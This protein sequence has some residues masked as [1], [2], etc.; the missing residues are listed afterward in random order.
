VGA[1]GA[2][3]LVWGI[4]SLHVSGRSEP[5]MFLLPVDFKVVQYAVAVMF[6]MIGTYLLVLAVLGRI[7]KEGLDTSRPGL[8]ACRWG[9]MSALITMLLFGIPGTI[10][11]LEGA[12]V[13]G[14]TVSGEACHSI[15]PPILGIPPLAE[16]IILSLMGS[17]MMLVA[18]R[19]EREPLYCLAF[20]AFML[21][22]GLTADMLLYLCL[23]A[24]GVA[25]IAVA[26]LVRWHYSVRR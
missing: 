17:H 26:R 15:L 13:L 7:R 4:T 25:G 19:H 22:A 16:G 24:G 12:F 3:M 6:L 21:V 8:A 5:R 11:L 10:L 1:Q 9:W 20:L 2:I 23:P 18:S 14:S